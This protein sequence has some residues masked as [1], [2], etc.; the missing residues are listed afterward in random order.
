MNR[1]CRLSILTDEVSQELEDVIRFAR[2]FS[3]DGIE[4]RSLF[5]KAFRDLSPPQIQEI[6]SRCRDAGLK[7]NGCATPVFKCDLDDGAAIDE[8]VEL[9]RRSLELAR[10]LGSELVRVFTFI[11]R[12]H[13]A[14][15]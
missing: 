10:V 13:P 14:T 2:D 1:W 12:S 8:H 7:V 6:A 15:S 4:L 9:F 3:L 5:G 11:R